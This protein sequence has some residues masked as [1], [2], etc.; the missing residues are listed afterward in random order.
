MAPSSTTVRAACRVDLAGGTLDIWPLGLL[1]PGACTVNLAIDVEVEVS[2]SRR[3]AGYVVRQSDTVAESSDLAGLRGEPSTA[4]VSLVGSHFEL[5]PSDLVIR[6]ASP[7][8]AGLGASSALTVALIVA[9]EEASGM[10][11]GPGMS[12]APL[13]G[14]PRRLAYL[15]RDF[16]AQLMGLPTGIQ[17][18][19][20]AILGGALVIDHL[21]GGEAPRRLDIDLKRLGRHLSLVF[22]GQ[23]HVSAQNNWRVVRRRLDG[24]DKSRRLFD[25]IRQVARELSGALEEGRLERVGEL[26]SEEWSHRCQLAES[27]S[28]RRID[29]LISL[30]QKVGAWGAKVCGAGGGGCVAILGPERVR[31][32]LEE[33]L[34]D[35]GMVLLAARPSSA[36][37]RLES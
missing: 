15:A 32:R 1:H 7:R 28:T 3:S 22:S 2:V 12:A 25:G 20:P 4:L 36:G 6:S 27:A 31:G 35:S 18:H 5:P 26:M 24:D 30:A 33:E 9:C 14:D 29:E 17:D 8:G 10:S 21:P 16:E 11:A 37:L 34:V 13:R 19:Y 23:S